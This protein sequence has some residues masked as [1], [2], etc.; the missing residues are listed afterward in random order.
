MGIYVRE[1]AS[2]HILHADFCPKGV[3]GYSNNP[4]LQTTAENGCGSALSPI[5]Q[6][7]VFELK[8][9]TNVPYSV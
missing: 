7:T 5:C 6:K 2:T 1:T 8:L 3:S 9:D 4:E